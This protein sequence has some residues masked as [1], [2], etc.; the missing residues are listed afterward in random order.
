LKNWCFLVL[1]FPEIGSDL[2]KCADVFP[3]RASGMLLV[4]KKNEGENNVGSPEE[5]MSLWLMKYEEGNRVKG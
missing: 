5:G 2:G 3:Y 1:V 4:N